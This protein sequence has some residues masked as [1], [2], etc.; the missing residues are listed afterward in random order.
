MKLKPKWNCLIL[1][2]WPEEMAWEHSEN[3]GRKGGRGNPK[4]GDP[5]EMDLMCTLEEIY[6]GCVKKMKITHRVTAI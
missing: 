5:I 6:N 2:E 4:K 1:I 3:F